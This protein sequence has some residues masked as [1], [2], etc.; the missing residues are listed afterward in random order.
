[1]GSAKVETRYR[2]SEDCT[3]EGCPSHV[4]TIEYLSVVNSYMVQFVKG[5]P[6]EAF[7]FEEVSK[8]HIRGRGEY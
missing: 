7:I 2:C 3:I 8:E 5:G 6:V 1:M 4:M